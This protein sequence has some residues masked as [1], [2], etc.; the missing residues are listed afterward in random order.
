MP[1]RFGLRLA[2]ALV[3]AS[4]PACGDRANKEEEPR[5]KF[6]TERDFKLLMTGEE[7]RTLLRPELS[8]GMTLEA[9]VE[10]DQDLTLSSRGRPSARTPTV[11]SARLRLEIIEGTEV[12]SL[13]AR[14]T[15]SDI[16]GTKIESVADLPSSGVAQLGSWQEVH[17]VRFDDAPPLDPSNEAEHAWMADVKR[18]L[19]EIMAPVPGEPVGV[20]A[21]WTRQWDDRPGGAKVSHQRTFRLESVSESEAV[22][23]V[24][25][26]DSTDTFAANGGS[27][28]RGTVRLVPGKFVVPQ[29]QTN[30]TGELKIRQPGHALV[31][32][33]LSGQLRIQPHGTEAAPQPVAPTEP[34]L[35]DAQ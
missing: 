22:V 19:V 3:L 15:V 13:A 8:V 23:T 10:Y 20:G 5:P 12:E 6:T 26:R 31:T 18:W 34:N 1:S 25:G 14:F 33:K 30:V 24:Y 27:D 35:P 32:G 4:A 16:R 28:I 11:G 17:R 29:T 9:A 21:S 7:P 2:C